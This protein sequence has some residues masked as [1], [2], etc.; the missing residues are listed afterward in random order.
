MADSDDEPTVPVICDAC[1][2][3]NRVALDDVAATVERH[4]ERVHDGEQVAEV[5][6][7]V[8]SALHDLLAADVVEEN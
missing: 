1:D 4:N 2:T 5:D 7:D 3:T 8:T 6:P